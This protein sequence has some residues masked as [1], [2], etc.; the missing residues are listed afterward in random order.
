MVYLVVLFKPVLRN[1]PVCR[2]LGTSNESTRWQNQN[3]PVLYTLC[4]RAVEPFLQDAVNIK[5]L[6]KF[7][8][9]L[10]NFVKESSTG[11]Y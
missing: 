1:I 8:K 2:M 11:V 7:R 4:R 10:S 5:N 3:K 9:Q 6:H